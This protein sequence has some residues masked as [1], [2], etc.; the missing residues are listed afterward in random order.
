MKKKYEKIR[1]AGTAKILENITR[2][3]IKNILRTKNVVN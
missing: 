2:E 3:N 1:Y